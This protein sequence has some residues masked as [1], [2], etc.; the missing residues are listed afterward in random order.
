MKLTMLEFDIKD[1]L[2]LSSSGHSHSYLAP[3]YLI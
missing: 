3:A 1:D 2:Q